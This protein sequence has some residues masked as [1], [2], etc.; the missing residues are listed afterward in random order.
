MTFLAQTGN[1]PP[2]VA[3]AGAG[4]GGLATAVGLHKVRKSELVVTASTPTL[5]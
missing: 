3:I 1:A 2:A 4:I 5:S